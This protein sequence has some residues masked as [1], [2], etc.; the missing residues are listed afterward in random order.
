MPH[1]LRFNN[2]ETLE[3]LLVFG[4]TSLFM[5]LACLYVTGFRFFEDKIGYSLVILAAVVI[6]MLL[7]Q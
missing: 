7:S 4:F 6:A 3:F 1:Y 2:G 5:S